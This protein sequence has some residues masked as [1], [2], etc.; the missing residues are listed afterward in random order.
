MEQMQRTTEELAETAVNRNK[1][2]AERIDALNALVRS[3]DP[4]QK[5]SITIAYVQPGNM[6]I[7]AKSV[8]ELVRSLAST[9]EKDPLVKNAAKA[10]LKKME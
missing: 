3:S 1:K 5:I 2:P 9:A 6:E 4:S 10:A 8:L 7:K